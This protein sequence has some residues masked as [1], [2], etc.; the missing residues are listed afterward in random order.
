[1][2]T[3]IQLNKMLSLAYALVVTFKTDKTRE[4]VNFQVFATDFS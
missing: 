3:M 2:K 4:I 1:M